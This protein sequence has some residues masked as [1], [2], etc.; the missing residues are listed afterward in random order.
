MKTRIV[1]A[2]LFSLVALSSGCTEEDKE[3]GSGLEKKEGE[4]IL[5]VEHFLN[6]N[7]IEVRGGENFRGERAAVKDL[8]IKYNKTITLCL[9]N[10]QKLTD[11]KEITTQKEFRRMY[12]SLEKDRTEGK[13]MSATL[14]DLHFNEISLKGANGVVKTTENWFFE[15]R[16]L[17]TG[18]I[19]VPYQD[20]EYETVYSV[21][22]E[23]GKWL[24]AGIELKRVAG[25]T[26]PRGEPKRVK[27]K[28]DF[29]QK[30]GRQ[31][32]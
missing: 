7:V 24:V 19:V 6:P 9:I 32:E 28:S 5:A 26:P 10:F 18:K 27:V 13:I 31:D 21:V 4:E 15:D 3:I 8:I 12:T 1:F 20:F 25:Y 16:D 22:K 11:L 30:G 2:L 17:K 23:D 14:W 29:V